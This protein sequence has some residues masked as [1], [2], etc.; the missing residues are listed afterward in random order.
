M[1]KKLIIICIMLLSITLSS[2]SVDKGPLE[3]I[4]F[5]YMEGVTS[6]GSARMVEDN[7]QIG[8]KYKINY[9]MLNATDLLNTRIIK[10][11]AHIAIVPTTLAA[12]SFNK[13]LGYV[14][15]GTST[16][17]NLYIVGK[18]ELSSLD[19]L[20]GKTLHT[21]GR[22][23]TPDVVLSFI[24]DHNGIDREKEVEMVYLNGAAEVGPLLIAGKADYGLLPEPILSAVLLKNPDL[25]VVFDLNSMWSEATGTT[26]G[27]PQSSL[28]IKKEL[29]DKDPKFVEDFLKAYVE[30]QNWGLDNIEA[31]GDLSEKLVLGP[32]KMAIVNGKDRL[33][34]HDFN[35]EDS[36]DEYT[37]YYEKILEFAPEFIGGKVPGEEIYYKR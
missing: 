35:M 26:K 19:E 13:D 36:L 27:Y 29:I 30:S 17:G 34:L 20:R 6:L 4:T 32:P 24:M 37:V 12:Q 7:V 9:E 21:F 5:S 3:E 28:V 10:Q 15:C 23:L 16:W 14:I 8:E 2:C 33:G 25:K 22:G 11:E 18:E 31:L 1:S